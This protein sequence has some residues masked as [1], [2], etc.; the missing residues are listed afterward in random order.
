MKQ[1]LKFTLATITGIVLTSILG[2][3]FLFG[4]IGAMSSS[5]NVPTE[6]KA[7]S[8]YELELKGTLVDRSDENPLAGLS[9]VFGQPEDIQLGLDDILA[10]I[11][12]AKSDPNITGIYLKGGSLMGGFASMK[13]IRDALADFKKSGKFIV[14][15]ADNYLQSNYYLA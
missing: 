15:Y 5:E 13:E 8:V 7:N 10:N 1:F 3:L 4:I 14:A 12:K 6:L 9:E 11:Q 2:L